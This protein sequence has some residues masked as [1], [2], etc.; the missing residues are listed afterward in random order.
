[1]I[2]APRHGFAHSPHA[3][4]A[5]KLLAA[6]PILAVSQELGKHVRELRLL[7]PASDATTALA[8]YRDKLTAAIRRAYQIELFVSAEQTALVLG[9]KEQA[10]SRSE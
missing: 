7:T 8:L 6:A 10:T 5:P 2:D 3:I 4:D 9:R 1:M